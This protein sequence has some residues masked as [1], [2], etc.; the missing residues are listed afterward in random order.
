M[1]GQNIQMQKTLWRRKAKSKRLKRIRW[2]RL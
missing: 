1:D 2:I